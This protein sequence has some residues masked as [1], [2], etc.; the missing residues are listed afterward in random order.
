MYNTTLGGLI[1]RGSADESRSSGQALSDTAVTS[2]IS[3]GC[4]C[5]RKIVAGGGKSTQMVTD[6]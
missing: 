3:A 4:M 6:V 5:S 1:F 2:A